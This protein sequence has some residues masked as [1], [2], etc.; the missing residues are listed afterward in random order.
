MAVRDRPRR[1]AANRTR[2]PTDAWLLTDVVTRLRR[3]LRASI[4]TEYPWEA[5]PMA[6]VE[7]LQRLCDEPGLR[8]GDLA[9]RHHLA[10]NT[11]S[12]IVQQLVTAGLA[13]RTTDARDRRAVRLEA[14]ALGRKMLADWQAAHERRFAE[15]LQRLS[16]ADRASVL[17]AV[18]ALDRLVTELER[19]RPD[20]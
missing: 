9:T 10:A 13:E 2:Q 3:T 5:L 14:T 1:G 6:Q 4:R 17:A 19:D 20:G 16:A 7:I 11:V 8:L 12:G 15:A 18:P